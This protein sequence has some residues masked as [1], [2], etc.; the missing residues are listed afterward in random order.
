M[1][2][3]QTFLL[4]PLFPVLQPLMTPTMR[5]SATAGQDVVEM[6]LSPKFARKSGIYTM[7]EKDQ[8]SPDSLDEEV[9]NQI[10]AQ[11]SIWV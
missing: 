6:T 7:L 2:H 11:T 10:R 4:K 5:N 9:Q 1:Q 8:S 3:K